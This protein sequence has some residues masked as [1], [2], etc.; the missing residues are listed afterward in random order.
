[1]KYC[2]SSRWNREFTSVLQKI[3]EDKAVPKDRSKRDI[4]YLKTSYTIIENMWCKQFD[5]IKVIKAVI[6]SEAPQ[7]GD[8]ETYIY[9]EKADHSSFFYYNDYEIA[10]KC[11]HP[12]QLT[13][14]NETQK[15]KALLAVLRDL[16]VLIIDISPFAL[17]PIKTAIN[18]HKN[19]ESSVQLSKSEYRE[20]LKFT[21]KYHLLPKLEETRKKKAIKSVFAYRYKRIEEYAGDIVKTSL[22][23]VGLIKK[24]TELEIIG[25]NYCIDR[26]ALRKIYSRVSGKGDFRGSR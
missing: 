24:D 19:T 23:R 11:F 14:I 9:N 2:C 8:E 4:E 1:M 16:G 7:F 20:M 10:L 25:K 21:T 3:Y 6:I 18:Y 13:L 5:N 17:N 15:K 12:R 22:E 26:D